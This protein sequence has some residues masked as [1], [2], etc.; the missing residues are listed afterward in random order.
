MKECKAELSFL[1]HTTVKSAPL[2]PE[3]N[4]IIGEDDF[5]TMTENPPTITVEKKT[6]ARD[7]TALR[8]V[9][10]VHAG[11]NGESARLLLLLRY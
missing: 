8:P 5:K 6:R 9:I 2:R 4:C 10:P 3:T 7:P 11:M 1:A